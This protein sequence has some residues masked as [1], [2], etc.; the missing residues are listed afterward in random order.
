LE[1][2]F[3]EISKPARQRR[4]P[5]IV[6]LGIA[7]QVLLLGMIAVLFRRVR[8]DPVAFSVGVT[9]LM[10]ASVAAALRRLPV[11]NGM[12]CWNISLG[13]RLCRV[14]TGSPITSLALP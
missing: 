3:R 11:L 2:F 7:K 1:Q 13:C 8:L 9:M 6:G 10:I 4:R 12:A 14:S 5:L